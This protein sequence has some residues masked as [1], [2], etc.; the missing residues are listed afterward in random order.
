MSGRVWAERLN[1]FILKCSND[2]N[3]SEK[4]A[5]NVRK[6]KRAVCDEAMC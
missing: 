6:E 2:V 5:E 1:I 3:A 4:A